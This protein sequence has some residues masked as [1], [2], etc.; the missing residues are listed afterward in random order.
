[1][2]RFFRD[3][4]AS[5]PDEHTVFAGLIHAPDGSGTKLAAIVTCHCGPLP[6]GE[7]AMRPLKR[8]G[9]PVADTIAPM[10]YC[11]LNVMLDAAY[12][13][14]AFNYWKSSFLA[15]LTEDAIDAMVECFAKCPTP[16]GRGHADRRHRHGLPAPQR[17]LQLPRGVR[18]DGPGNLRPVHCVGS[19]NLRCDGAVYRLRSLCKLSR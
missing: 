13:K 5:L 14:G 8:F 18:M 6:N 19:A 15:G 12:P 11:Q 17:R 2:L 7:E 4:T 16:M 9:S 1:V 10:P 3:C